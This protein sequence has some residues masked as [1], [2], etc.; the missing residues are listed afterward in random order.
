M[1]NYEQISLFTDSE[2]SNSDSNYI[3]PIKDTSFIKCHQQLKLSKPQSEFI[4][5]FAIILS[6]TYGWYSNLC[7]L[8]WRAKDMKSNR[9]IFHL[10]ATQIIN[11]KLLPTPMVSYG[12]VA[13]KEEIVGMNKVKNGKRV[14]GIQLNDLAAHKL[15]PTPTAFDWNSARH[16]ELWEK[17]KK[18]YAEKGINLHCS[19]RQK[20]TLGLL[21][22]PTLMDSTNS[23]DMTAAAKIMKGA[24][25]RSSGQ[26][27][28]KSLTMKV[29][30]AILEQDPELAE[31]LAQRKMEKRE[32]LP[33]QQEFVTWIRSVTKSKDL[34]EKSNIKLTTVEH[35][36][37]KDDNG[38]SF[39]SIEEWL[40]IREFLNPSKELD[41]KMTETTSI[42]WQG[43]DFKEGKNSGNTNK[44][45]NTSMRLSP[46]FVLE[47]MGF[48]TDWTLL[49]FLKK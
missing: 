21:P 1:A 47:M 23:G 20:A 2:L 43:A 29:H 38:F 34:S 33:T 12:G 45:K 14:H 9:F 40:I 8:S 7:E 48:P 5:S 31:E 18:K 25:H 30:E 4:G 36:F 6:E 41:I 11:N 16:A 13:K 44:S 39:P 42:E 49:P 46:H 37:R 17:D 28:Q 32:N 27:I 3:N 22:T 26:P 24:T 19:L 10:N 15:L 35:W